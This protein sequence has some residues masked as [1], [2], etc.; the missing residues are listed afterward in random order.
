MKA[1]YTTL[2]ALIVIGLFGGCTPQPA[3]SGPLN[4]CVVTGGHG[5]DKAR[6]QD[7]FA[8]ADGLQ[9]TYT[10]LDQDG[11]SF[12]DISRWDYDVMI[13][14]NFRMPIAQASREN[15]IQLTHRGTGFVILHHG[16]AAFPDWPQW[17]KIVGA[18]YFLKDTEED[19]ILW[20]R[21]TYQH[22]VDIP[23]EPADTSH[24][25]TRGI[26]PFVIFDETYKGYRLE[27]GNHLLLTTDHPAGQKEVAWTRTFNQSRICYI[28]L[29]HGQ[30]AYENPHYRKLL[31]QA[32]R[33][34][35]SNKMAP[36]DAGH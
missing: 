22:D 26:V 17:R 6:F 32:V 16:I 13:F 20:K 4:I 21:C 5:Y 31:Q 30:G 27:A 10:E 36:N 29:G 23:I 3:P 2:C 19:G 9:L 25:V 7:M 33:W 34:T 12:D 14:Y 28:Q 35:A 15:L 18:K 11:S 1:C 24:P 8:D